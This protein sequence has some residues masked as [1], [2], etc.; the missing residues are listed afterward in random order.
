VVVIWLVPLVL[1]A[2][3]AVPSPSRRGFFPEGW[4]WLVDGRCGGAYGQ[5]TQDRSELLSE[6]YL[7]HLVVVVAVKFIGFA[8]VRWG[9]HR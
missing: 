1:L 7:L 4:C 3:T 5:L 2:P 9:A 8:G 6:S